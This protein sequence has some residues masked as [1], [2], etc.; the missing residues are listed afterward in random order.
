MAADSPFPLAASQ[1]KTDLE[2]TADQA[3]NLAESPLWITRRRRRGPV[4][5]LAKSIVRDSPNAIVRIDVDP[6]K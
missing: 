6:A 3:V 5:E 4:S 2:R 1:I